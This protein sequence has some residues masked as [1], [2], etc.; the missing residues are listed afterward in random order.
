MNFFLKPF[1][2]ASLLI[3]FGVLI[4]VDQFYPIQIPFGTIFWA[5]VLIALGVQ[6][7]IM[8][9]S[10]RCW[11]FGSDFQSMKTK[12]SE[13]HREDNI[14]FGK[15]T[16]DYSHLTQDQKKKFFDVS[17]VFGQGTIIINPLDPIKVKVSSVF[18]NA[19]L[20]DGRSVSFGDKEYETESYKS[21]PSPIL[22]KVEVVFGEV[23]V[24]EL[25][26]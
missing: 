12:I 21:S 16:I 5:V 7:L 9:K 15:G 2:W 8:P 13:R 1:F 25:L 6:L 26:P 10:I 4:L 3:I 14:L 18:G 19:T 11:R 23:S 22:I 17:V 20:P 24:E